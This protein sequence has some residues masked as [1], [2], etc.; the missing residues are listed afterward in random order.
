MRIALALLVAADTPA[1]VRNA[2]EEA[3]KKAA[4]R[5]LVAYGGEL[6]YGTWA[7][8]RVPPG[9]LDHSI[10]YAGPPAPKAQTEEG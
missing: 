1:D 10:S 8:D 5:F 3:L 4:D 9:E 7:G 6:Y 2:L